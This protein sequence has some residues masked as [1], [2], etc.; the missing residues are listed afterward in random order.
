MRV[1]TLFVIASLQ[2]IIV[3]ELT[4]HSWLTFIS[5]GKFGSDI[6]IIHVKRACTLRKTIAG[7]S[8]KN[9]AFQ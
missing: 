4:E 5:D 7:G 2:L 3:L 6:I 1:S 9:F 8:A